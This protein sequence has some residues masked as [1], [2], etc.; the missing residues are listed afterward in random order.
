[1][2]IKK[3]DIF[4]NHFHWSGRIFLVKQGDTFSNTCSLSVLFSGLSKI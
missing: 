3:K 4:S 1:M 2:I